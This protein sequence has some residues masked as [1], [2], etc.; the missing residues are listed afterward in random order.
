MMGTVYYSEIS[1]RRVCF[2]DGPHVLWLYQE[3]FAKFFGLGSETDMELHAEGF[4]GII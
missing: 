3:Q 1:S 4:S 2:R